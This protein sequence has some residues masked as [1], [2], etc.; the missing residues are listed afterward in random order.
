M[1]PLKWLSLYL[2]LPFLCFIWACDFPLTK[3]RK[4][5]TKKEIAKKRKSDLTAPPVR[6]VLPRRGKVVK[7][8]TGTATIEAEEKAD[9]FA[10]I[11][12][13]VK[14]LKKQEGDFVK[15]GEIL[16]LLEDDRLKLELQ[17]AAAELEQKTSLFKITEKEYKKQLVSQTDYDQAK[18]Q[19]ELAKIQKQQAE[20]NLS[21]T[22]IVA[23]FDGIITERLVNLGQQILANTKVFSMFNPESMVAFL[24]VPERDVVLLHEKQKATIYLESVKKK[25]RALV[26]R[27]SPVIDE[28]SGMVKITLSILPP[29]KGLRLG[30][31]VKAEII[32][33]EKGNSLLIPKKAVLYKDGNPVCFVVR[34]NKRVDMCHLKLGESLQDEIEIIEGIQAQDSVVVEGHYDLEDGQRVKI[35]SPQSQKGE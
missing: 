32:I 29:R 4:T 18:H 3:G 30:A 20:F 34:K 6:V 15:K 35:F 10:E 1:Q 24:Y 11:G 22:K 23:P 25:Y 31:L 17:K 21:K 33:R 7:K 14:E 9:V 12:G 5:K 8:I 2:F 16:V 27:I 19:M 13:I 26:K 28:E